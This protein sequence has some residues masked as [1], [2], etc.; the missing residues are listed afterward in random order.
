MADP[1]P[2]S[3]FFG[4][5]WS[6]FNHALLLML[7]RSRL[8]LAV[9][10]SLLPVLIPLALKFLSATAVADEGSVVFVRLT[11]DLYLPLL[12]PLL[13]L[14]F[15]TMLI[16]EDVEGQTLSYMLTR[17]MPRSAW[18]IGRFFAYLLVTTV[19]L[20]LSLG[21]VYVA[22][23]TLGGFNL[24]RATFVLLAH[25]SGLAVLS[26]LAC[27]ALSMFLGALTK[28]PIIYGVIFFFG[29]QRL[30]V[31]V[32]GLV[33]FMTLQ[34]YIDMMLPRLATAR[35]DTVMVDALMEF[36]RQV[37]VIDAS[38]ALATLLVISVVFIALSVAAVRWREYA[39]S[40]AI[41]ST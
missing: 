14:F 36:Q 27:G 40:Q 22:C 31:Q 8:V 12:A 37:F 18:V 4:Y 13:S 6:C 9:V 23:T 32:P 20:L 19:M 28:R 11:Q 10:V 34:K 24:S 35:E 25:Y 39:T 26:L 2:N 21:M 3:N 38:K 29:W 5:T 16:G 33:D 7:R 30:V 15:A 1:V 41:G 17:P